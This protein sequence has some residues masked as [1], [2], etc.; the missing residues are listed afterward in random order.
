MSNNDSCIQRCNMRATRCANPSSLESE[1]E[2]GKTNEVGSIIGYDM[3]LNGDFHNVVTHGW[4]TT[5]SAHLLLPQHNSSDHPTINLK[6]KLQHLKSQ[7][8]SWRK[9]ELTKNEHL[10][11]S[12]KQKINVLEEK[13]EN[14]SLDDQDMADRLSHLK[15]L[16]DLKHLKILN[17]K[18][19]AKVNWAIKGDENSKFFHGIINN[20]FS[21]S[22]INGISIHGSWVTNPI[23]VT[24]HIF[25]FHKFNG[26]LTKE[27]KI[28]KGLGQ[29][30]PLSPFFF[31]ISM[32]AFH[33]TIQEAKDNSIFE[34]I[35]VGHNNV[36]PSPWKCII[37]LDKCLY[38]L[39][40]DLHISLKGKQEMAPRLLSGTIFR[41]DWR[42]PIKDGPEKVQLDGLNNLILHFVPSSSQDSWE[43][44]LNDSQCFTVSSM[45]KHIESFILSIDAEKLRWNNLIPIKLNILTW[46][47]SLD[48]IP[49]RSNL[50]S[51]GIDLDSR[52]CPVCNDEIKT[53]QHL[54]IDCSI[55]KSSWILVSKWWGFHD[56]P[57]DLPSLIKR[58]DNTNLPT[59]FAHFFDAV[60]Q[61]TLSAI[62]NLRNKICFDSKPSRKDLIGDDIKLL[63]HLWISH[64]SRNCK[65]CW[66]NWTSDPVIASLYLSSL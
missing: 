13:A 12:L 19:K 39:N 63:S 62:W 51:K 18:Q 33:V 42:R 36:D 11:D 26:P 32:E 47:I 5:D 4:S 52:L 43:F 38:K 31:I 21:R 48:R 27:F 37:G 40:N 9:G 58:A 54:L 53:S 64:R 22:R 30:D 44:S 25:N 15:T 56:Y 55:A 8:R 66:L 41:L 14:G 45:R 59:K 3:L 57:K 24:S 16:E 46:R 10:I 17:L 23:L 61:T 28:Q 35:Q 6:R 34:G 49:T 20:K 2:I 60:V 7:I 65:P 1:H 29:G 50:D